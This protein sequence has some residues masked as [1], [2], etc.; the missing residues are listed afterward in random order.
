MVYFL[1]ILKLKIIKRSENPTLAYVI[2][3]IIDCAIVRTTSLWYRWTSRLVR[4]PLSFFKTC[5]KD[6]S[7]GE[8]NEIFQSDD[9]IVHIYIFFCAEKGDDV[10]NKTNY[11]K[12]IKQ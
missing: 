4:F 5:H 10:N 11:L 1:N 6:H 7:F 8:K 3:L 12:T 9:G 2:L